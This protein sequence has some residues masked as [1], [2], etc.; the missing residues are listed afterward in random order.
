MNLEVG[1]TPIDV[2]KLS[3][4][5]SAEMERHGLQVT[6]QEQNGV[7]LIKGVMA[8]TVSSEPWP[9]VNQLEYRIITASGYFKDS[10][11]GPDPR[12]H[13]GEIGD[14]VEDIYG[15]LG[16]QGFERIRTWQPL[17]EYRRQNKPV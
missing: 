4:A 16:L 5:I 2:D 11:I 10:I 8:R 3:G 15:E 14:V 6:I 9:R 1:I 17:A 12:Y 7:H 13:G